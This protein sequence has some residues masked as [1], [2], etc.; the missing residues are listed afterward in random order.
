M[1]SRT[2]YQTKCSRSLLRYTIYRYTV[3]TKW[4]QV[5]VPIIIQYRV[6]TKWLEVAVPIIIQYTVGTKWLEVA[7]PIIIQYLKLRKINSIK[8]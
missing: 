6:G 4:L 1:T 2:E 5:A 7:V 3:L 8:F